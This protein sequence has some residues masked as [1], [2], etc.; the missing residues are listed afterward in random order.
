MRAALTITLAVLLAAVAS[1]MT[2]E[3]FR[4]LEFATII[5]E[6][7]SPDGRESVVVGAAGQV[8]GEDRVAIGLFVEGEPRPELVAYFYLSA[9][10]KPVVCVQ[11][12]EEE[13]ACREVDGRRADFIRR[14]LQTLRASKYGHPER[15]GRGA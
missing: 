6:P 13:W 14:D 15:P 1:G 10:N 2:Y 12:A 7:E 8:E 5:A 3:Q 11:R 4:G 9:N